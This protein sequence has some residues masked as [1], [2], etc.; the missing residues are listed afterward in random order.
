MVKVI[1]LIDIP[2]SLSKKIYRQMLEELCGMT[3]DESLEK[4][5]AEVLSGS[6]IGVN[7]FMVKTETDNFGQVYEYIEIKNKKVSQYLSYQKKGN[8]F[9]KFSDDLNN[10]F[11]KLEFYLK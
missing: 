3:Q 2:K 7:Q 4:S 5:E 1:N 6:M 8:K 10:Q 9:F 11:T